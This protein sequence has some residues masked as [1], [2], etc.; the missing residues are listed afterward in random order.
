MEDLFPKDEPSSI[1]QF[2]FKP[3]ENLDVESENQDLLFEHGTFSTLEG[4]QNKTEAHRALHF[5]CDH[6]R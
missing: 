5:F 3:N 2:F 4:R 1:K 6:N